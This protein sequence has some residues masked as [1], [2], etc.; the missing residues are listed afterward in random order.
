MTRRST[1]RYD[2]AM[3]SLSNEI[4]LLRE[5]NPVHLA[6]VFADINPYLLKLLASR[7]W[8]G[9]VAEDLVQSAWETFFSGVERFEGRSQLKVY[10][11]GIVLNKTREEGR[12]QGRIVLEDD[13]G[14]VFE[15]SFTEEGWWRV[16]PADP[17]QLF[18]SKE[19]KR[20]IEECLD[21]LTP[22][23]NEAF[24]LKEIEGENSE[25]ICKILGVTVTNLGVLVFRAK[26]KLRRCLEGKLGTRS[27][28]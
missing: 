23:Q 15:N 18:E 7:G 27:K 2:S 20:H 10:L 3:T 16:E 14:S 24:R 8:R 22:S 1:R 9:P 4:Q 11:A 25:A 21:G 12:R 13:A 19:I 26:E 5:R 17:S 6:K 28:T